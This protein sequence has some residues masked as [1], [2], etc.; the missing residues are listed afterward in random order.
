[1]ASAQMSTWD[2]VTWPYSSAQKNKHPH[3]GTRFLSEI[4]EGGEGNRDQMTPHNYAWDP[5]SGLTLIDAK[6]HCSSA[7]KG[8]SIPFVCYSVAL[9]FCRLLVFVSD[10]VSFNTRRPDSCVDLLSQSSWW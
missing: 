8:H 9:L 4:P 6:S 2:D 3:P 10:F 1:M 7:C 5:P